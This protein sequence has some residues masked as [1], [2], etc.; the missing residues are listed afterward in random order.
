[1][2]AVRTLR[3]NSID[4]PFW[5][6]LTQA[7][8]FGGL[9]T[10]IV[11]AGARNLKALK[12]VIPA[13]VLGG[14]VRYVIQSEIL[15]KSALLPHTFEDIRGQLA[16]DVGLSTAGFA[17][18]FSIVLRTI[19]TEVTRH[20]RTRAELALAEQVQ[21]SLAPPLAVKNAFYEVEGRSAPS[22]QM[23]GD[24]LDAVDE[25]GAVAVYVSDV[26]GHG[27]QAGVFMGMV[28]SS[29]RM[30]L[31]R[32]GPLSELLGDLNRV[33]FNVKTTP[34]TYVTFACLRCGPSGQVEYSLAGSGPIL[35]YRARSKTTSQLA[36]EQFPL[37]LFAKAAF[38][39][40]VVQIEPGDILAV[41]TDG[42]PEAVDASDQQFGLDRIG[43]ILAGHPTGP[44]A[45][46]VE[47]VFTAVRSH[48]PQTDD[49]TLVLVRAA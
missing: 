40:G 24:L 36:M 4:K 26:A 28:K 41:M 47:S 35:H 14:I 22:S 18:G 39:S 11:G 44:L 15:S 2:D 42:I 19:A 16:L 46:L 7:V 49:E 43:E 37:G 6:M 31:L 10:L 48:G 33:V 34:A 45:E 32:C 20:I 12:I 30:A 8:L 17:L 1:M 29:V 5:W 13:A 25:P 38:Q 9:A 27:I 3:V 21:Q 23:G